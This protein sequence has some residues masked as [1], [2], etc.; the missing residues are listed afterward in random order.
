MDIGLRGLIQIACADGQTV[1]FEY[2]VARYSV[3]SYSSRTDTILSRQY[4]YDFDHDTRVL[5]QFIRPKSQSL[6]CRAIVYD[7]GEFH[8]GGRCHFYGH[9][10]DQ[11]ETSSMTRMMASCHDSGADF[12]RINANSTTVSQDSDRTWMCIWKL[13]HS[14]I[15]D[16]I[17]A[18]V[19]IR[20]MVPQP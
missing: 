9:H 5:D 13:S 14:A 1:N 6:P 4:F 12:A 8:G 3:A 20:R 7:H 15:P 17:F 10:N 19:M 18:M 2:S 11:L 16:G